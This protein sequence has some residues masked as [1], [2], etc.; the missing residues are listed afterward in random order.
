MTSVGTTVI[1]LTNE[2]KSASARYSATQ[3]PK[4]HTKCRLAVTSAL[5]QFIRY[6]TLTLSSIEAEDVSKCR[7]QMLN[8]GL[9]YLKTCERSVEK[10]SRWAVTLIF[11]GAVS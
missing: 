5:A 11:D 8:E 7:E 6:A 2:L 3:G 1:G 9:K 4:I 10:I